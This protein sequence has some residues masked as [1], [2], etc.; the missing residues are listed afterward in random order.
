[1]WEQAQIRNSPDRTGARTFSFAGLKLEQLLPRCFGLRVNMP[2]LPTG[3]GSAHGLGR[4]V[5]PELTPCKL[6]G[7]D[8]YYYHIIVWLTHA[9]VS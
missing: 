5:L 7:V 3:R 9:F 4:I 2:H 8:I 6:R 1:M